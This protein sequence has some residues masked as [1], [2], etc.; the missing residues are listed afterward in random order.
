MLHGTINL[1]KYI[2]SSTAIASF[3][4]LFNVGSGKLRATLL[5]M[6]S[7]SLVISHPTSLPDSESRSPVLLDLPPEIMLSIIST[8][9]SDSAI[10]CLNACHTLHNL[11]TKGEKSLLF[12]SKY[13]SPL[14]AENHLEPPA[15][16]RLAQHYQQILALLLDEKSRVPECTKA[17]AL[18]T[19]FFK[20]LSIAE[21]K[22]ILAPV[23]AQY[24]VEMLIALFERLATVDL[25][26]CLNLLMLV[27]AL[28]SDIAIQFLAEKLLL[29]KERAEA[30]VQ[31]YQYANEPILHVALE[32]GEE[33]I[34]LALLK[35]HPK[36][37]DTCSDKGIT[38]LMKACAKGES[39][40]ALIISLLKAGAN[41]NLRDKQDRTA[42][43]YISSITLLL[44]YD[45]L[46]IIN[47]PV[48]RIIGKSIVNHFT[49]PLA[50]PSLDRETFVRL[51]LIEEDKFSCVYRC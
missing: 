5:A 1:L 32:E 15:Q 49:L 11:Y 7:S 27:E 16:Q 39:K 13:C 6:K 3:C 47:A 23:A 36:W 33:S 14:L 22:T 30:F 20:H 2:D 26:L 34:L 28:P 18:A 43:N 50:Y 46:L 4:A 8:L 25:P 24:D 35:T 31:R 10:N 12:I 19:L 40:K 38:L 44:E 51:G 42:E 48:S 17:A 9:D 21:V 45:M 29:D 41:P 37:I